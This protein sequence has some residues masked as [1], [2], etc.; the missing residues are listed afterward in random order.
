MAGGL[1][2]WVATA[3]EKQNAAMIKQTA[4]A[5]SRYRQKIARLFRGGGIAESPA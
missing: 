5:R 1:G 3:D 4:A 2:T